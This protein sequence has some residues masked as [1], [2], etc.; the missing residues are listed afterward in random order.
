MTMRKEALLQALTE[1]I[2]H[3]IKIDGR[4]QEQMNKYLGRT[5]IGRE[6]TNRTNNYLFIR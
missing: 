5:K 4:L 6:I 1:I 2:D 3:V